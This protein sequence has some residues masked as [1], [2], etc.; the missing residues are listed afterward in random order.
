[1]EDQSS[2]SEEIF[3]D[4]NYPTEPFLLS[5]IFITGPLIPTMPY[6]VIRELA[7]ECGILVS[8]ERLKDPIYYAK[9]FTNIANFKPPLLT[10]IYEP[11]QKDWAVHF[12]N[13]LVEW[14]VNSL[15]KATHFLQQSYYIYETNSSNLL[16]IHLF[17]NIGL[18]RPELPYEINACILYGIC[19]YFQFILPLEISY[20][21]IHNKVL[22]TIHPSNLFKIKS[23]EFLTDDSSSE[24]YYYKQ[25]KEYENEEVHDKDDKKQNNEKQDK[26][27]EE[28]DQEENE[29]EDTEEYKEES[30]SQDYR[31]DEKRDEER[32][33]GFIFSEKYDELKVIGSLFQD[34]GYLQNNFYPITDAQAVVTGAIV[35]LTDLTVFRNPLIEFKKL[36]KGEN[37]K[38]KVWRDYQEK[39]PNLLDLNLYFNPFLPDYFYLKETL[40]HHLSLFSFPVYDFIGMTQ[41]EIIQE[42]FMNENFHIGWHPN[43][44]TKETPIFLE[45]LDDLCLDEII[46][47]GTLYEN[48]LK[49]T[50]WRELN[51]IFSKTSSFTNPFE[52]KS[53]FDVHKIHRLVKLGNFI[54]NP[55]YDY[56]YLFTKYTEKIKDQIKECLETIDEIFFQQRI[57]SEGFLEYKDIYNQSPKELKD[58]FQS[59][60]DQLFLVCMYMR[61]WRGEG[62]PYPIEVVPFAGNDRT[63]K[64]TI[65]GIFI[66]DDWNRKTMSVF[67][68]FPLIIWKNEFVKSRLIEQGL[69]IGQRIEIVKNGENSNISSCIRMS[70]NV[71]GATYC[72][73]CKLFDIE[74]KFRIDRLRDIQ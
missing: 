69:T 68:D 8:M 70:S 43:I 11:M 59:C 55:S 58:I 14:D 13:P 63:E 5:K 3:F 7:L 15:K 36:R 32:D 38:N 6:I 57:E 73:Y 18:A 65:E 29:E 49:F 66:L 45:I 54:L 27:V 16:G 30:E 44:I 61:G 19:R 71:L 64:N 25:E 12:V 47:Y 1:M 4:S 52:L 28:E 42:L 33:E 24:N 26:H 56:Q 34:V 17:S 53:I 2:S 48:N 10:N 62:D 72:F 51:E 37:F 40:E 21:E 67:Y 60:L 22:E 20:E 74:P 35:Y 9:I 50:T 31:D 39:N 23:V 41:F 46:V